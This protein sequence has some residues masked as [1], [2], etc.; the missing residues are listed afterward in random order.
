MAE[1]ADSQTAEP[2]EPPSPRWH[3][4]LDTIVDTER[5]ALRPI[6]LTAYEVAART[7]RLL[8]AL[9][10]LPSVR[11]FQGIHPDAEGI[12]PI[13]HA[14][15]A[16]QRVL[17]IESVAWPPG[18]YQIT[19]DG[20]IHCDG[21]YIGQSASLLIAAVRRWR[22]R[23]PPGHQVSAVVV[24][25]PTSRDDMILPPTGCDLAWV[26]AGAAVHDIRACLPPGDAPVSMRALAEL[27]SAT[28]PW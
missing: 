15:I 10:A 12:P 21:V 19:P 25:H 2:S 20:R 4:S 27:I 14:I 9:L 22:T 11:I 16:G 23:L 18:G 17:L 8:A 1:P 24:V 5:R 3:G 13:G 6:G 26:H 7:G 28:T